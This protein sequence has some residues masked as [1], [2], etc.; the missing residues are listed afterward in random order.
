M[1]VIRVLAGQVRTARDGRV[2]SEDASPGFPDQGR[3]VRV[4]DDVVSPVVV[5]LDAG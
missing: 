2:R 3:R 5:D 1:P 4:H